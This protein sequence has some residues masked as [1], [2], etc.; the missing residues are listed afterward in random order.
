MLPPRPVLAVAVLL[1][2][3]LA[4]SLGAEPPVVAALADAARWEGQAVALEGWATGLRHETEATRFSLV[5]GTH[6]VAV[7]VADAD[8]DLVAGDRVRAEGRLT[9]WQG[10]LRL[11]VED[12]DRLRIVP[13]P[14]WDSPT[15]DEL[16][17]E[18]GAWAGR[19]LLLLGT[20]DG[21][22]LVH[23]GRS[24]A[25]GDGAWP[26]EGPVQVRGFLREDPACL[27]HRLDAREV[28]PWTP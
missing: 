13:G 12:R 4:W 25:L 2:G 9:R 15:W 27:C 8:T 14:G 22:R 3:G 1:V 26:T 20:V 28:W 23:G 19:P 10:A 5:D 7:R 24:L 18:P 6:V 11:D 17:A 16:G 21:D